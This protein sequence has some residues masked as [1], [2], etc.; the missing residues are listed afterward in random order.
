MV[1][2]SV[3]VSAET[4]SQLEFRFRYRY[5]NQN[6]GFGRSLNYVDQIL[7]NFEPPPISSG[8]NWTFSILSLSRHPSRTFHRHLI[9]LLL[10]Q[11]VIERPP[12]RQPGFWAVFI[13]YHPTQVGGTLT[14]P[15][16]SLHWAKMANFCSTGQFYG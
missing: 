2:V 3:T 14:C 12:E 7:P 4:I 13:S 8:K 9:P 10:V 6:S 11:V 5:R 1:S 16:A 15:H